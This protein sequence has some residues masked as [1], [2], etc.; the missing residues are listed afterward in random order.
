M[1]RR[2]LKD[3]YDKATTQSA[4][5]TEAK[6]VNSRLRAA[7]SPSPEISLH[8]PSIPHH[9][10]SHNRSP[11]S[12]SPRRDADYHRRHY[13]DYRHR[14]SDT[15]SGHYNGGHSRSYSGN[16]LAHFSHPDRKPAS[17]QPH[18]N[19]R[20]NHRRPHHEPSNDHKA[21][22]HQ[23]DGKSRRRSRSPTKLQKRS[24]DFIRA[25]DSV[26]SSSGTDQRGYPKSVKRNA[27]RQ[28]PRK[29]STSSGGS[30]TAG[31][32]MPPSRGGTKRPASDVLAPT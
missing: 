7:L 18:T 23:R 15:R 14:A 11:R 2:S 16:K 20:V 12:P 32:K 27:S 9:P 8:R 31:N 17:R 28:S 10:R 13:V 30:S 22:Y 1:E 24:P 29:S 5:R 4:P 26:D 21:Q 3:A 6:G 25:S 19:S